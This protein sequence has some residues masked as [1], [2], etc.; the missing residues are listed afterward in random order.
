MT[1]L[2]CTITAV[3]SLPKLQLHV[4]WILHVLRTAV[5][6]IKDRRAYCFALSF[7]SL[8]ETNSHS[9]A[10]ATAAHSSSGKIELFSYMH[11][12]INSRSPKILSDTRKHRCT[13]I[14]GTAV[15]SPTPR[16]V[17]A[18]RRDLPRKRQKEKHTCTRTLKLDIGRQTWELPPVCMSER[19]RIQAR[20]KCSRV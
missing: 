18:Q 15:C 13:I 14:Y 11:Y 5:C 9:T 19:E 4:A 1:V 7:F 17:T 16:S 2:L 3:V 12:A 8:T 10:A 6:P 20:E